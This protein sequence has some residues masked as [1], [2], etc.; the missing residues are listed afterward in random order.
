MTPKRLS[1][2]VPWLRFPVF[3]SRSAGE[4]IDQGLFLSAGELEQAVKR[5]AL[6]V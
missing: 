3:V 2:A 1:I 4:L 6:D 5:C